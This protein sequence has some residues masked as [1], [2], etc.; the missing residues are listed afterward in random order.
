MYLSGDPAPLDEKMNRIDRNLLHDRRPVS[1]PAAK[2][3]IVLF[4]VL[5]LAAW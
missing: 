1:G 3:G 5:L 4:A 2:D